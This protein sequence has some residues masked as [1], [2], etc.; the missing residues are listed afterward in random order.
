MPEFNLTGLGTKW[1]IL[2]DQ[3]IDHP[4]LES[5]LS[6]LISTFES[7]YSRFKEDSEISKLKKLKSPYKLSSELETM[8]SLGLLL[9]QKTLGCFNLNIGRLISAL[10]YD[11]KYSFR[12]DPKEINQPLNSY[13][14]KNHSLYFDSPLHLDLGALGKGYLIDKLSAYLMHHQINHFLIDGGGDIFAT[15]KNNHSPWRIAVEHPTDESKAIGTISLQNQAIATSSSQKRKFKNFHH[16]LN[17]IT[18]RPNSRLLSLSL[19]ASS[20]FIADALTTAL[21]VSPQNIWPTL[22]D[23]FNLEYLAVYPDFRVSKTPA[24]SNLF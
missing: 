4:S 6:G 2:I 15:N 3:D 12:P 17:P 7:Q 21:F 9:E 22:V 16:L 5:N 14:I 24:F 11:A 20:A 13:T 8:L 10:G 19:L 23:E 1:S 18:K